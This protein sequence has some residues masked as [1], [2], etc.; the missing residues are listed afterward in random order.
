MRILNCTSG[1]ILRDAYPAMPFTD[2]EAETPKRPRGK[3]AASRLDPKPLLI[4]A[5]C[6]VFLPL[7]P[8]VGRRLGRGVIDSRTPAA[9]LEL[10]QAKNVA[11]ADGR[12]T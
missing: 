7:V 10:S 4:Q 8:G 3:T 6:P 1:R 9:R 5:L 2:Q 12:R 11:G